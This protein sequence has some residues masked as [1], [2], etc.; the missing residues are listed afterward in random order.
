MP[1]DEA[2]YLED[3]TIEGQTVTFILFAD[4]WGTGGRLEIKIY[5][6]S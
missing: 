6:N 3:Y 5:E 1:Q 4:F 2:A